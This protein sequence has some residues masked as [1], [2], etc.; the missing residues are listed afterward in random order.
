ML[1][2]LRRR[3]LLMARGAGNGMVVGSGV[4]KGLGA[5]GDRVKEGFV[6]F[7]GGCFQEDSVG[8]ITSQVF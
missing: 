6:G 1:Q 3:Y 8:G 2:R 4:N 5:A 7:L